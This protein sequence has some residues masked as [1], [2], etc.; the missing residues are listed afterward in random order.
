ML[1]T[2]VCK[3]LSG[4]IATSLNYVSLSIHVQAVRI[5]PDCYFITISCELMYNKSKSARMR[6][7]FGMQ[8][9]EIMMRLERGETLMID[10]AW[11]S[12]IRI[13]ND[14]PARRFVVR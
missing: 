6:E 5:I 12:Y 9:D 1:A 8:I 10:D 14:D 2:C 3:A 4:A 13:Q 11:R 7:V